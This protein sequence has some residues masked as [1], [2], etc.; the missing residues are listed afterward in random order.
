[1]GWMREEDAEQF[2][3][4]WTH[5]YYRIAELGNTSKLYTGELSHFQFSSVHFSSVVQSCLTLCDPLDCSPPGSSIH[6]ILQARVLEWVAISFS[7]GSSRP[8]DQTQVSHSVGRCFNLWATS[9]LYLTL[10]LWKWFPVHWESTSGYTESTGG[11]IGNL[12][13]VN[14]ILQEPSE[15]V[16][17]MNKGLTPSLPFSLMFLRLALHAEYWMLLVGLPQI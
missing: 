13:E 6:G 11:G 15:F 1:M 8:R 10:M 14:T 4:P 3:I 9:V 17:G 12:G 2:T 16:C 5:S 7:R